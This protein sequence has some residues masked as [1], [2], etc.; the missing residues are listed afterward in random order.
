MSDNDNSEE[1]E[2]LNLFKEPEGYY[3]PEKQHTFVSHVTL[4]GQTLTLRLVGHNP[5]WVGTQ[6]T[7][8]TMNKPQKNVT[9]TIQMPI[10]FI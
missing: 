1:D 3:Q 2:G 6:R 10:P 5:L 9:N 8:L 4:N 7:L